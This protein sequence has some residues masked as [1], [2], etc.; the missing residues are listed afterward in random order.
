MLEDILKAT[1]VGSG[2]L[3]S[4]DHNDDDGGAG[5]ESCREMKIGPGLRGVSSLAKKTD[6]GL[7]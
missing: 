4:S 2:K 6:T 5:M 7:V 1:S 3:H